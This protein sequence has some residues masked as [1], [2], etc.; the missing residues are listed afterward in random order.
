MNIFSLCQLICN[1]IPLLISNNFTADV[2]LTFET[3]TSTEF[4]SK[5][6][7]CVVLSADGNFYAAGCG[8]ALPRICQGTEPE[9]CSTLLFPHTDDLLCYKK[10][11]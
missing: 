2:P 7:H 8:L 4:D 9:A 11:L 1:D 5:K 6:G 3:W 10:E